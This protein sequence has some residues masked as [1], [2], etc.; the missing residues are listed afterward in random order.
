MEEKK[1]EVKI[2]GQIA[3]KEELDEKMKDKNIRLVQ[4]N[5]TSY[6]V[7]NHFVE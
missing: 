3:T 7:L 5:E 4:E 6:R 1:E 2:N